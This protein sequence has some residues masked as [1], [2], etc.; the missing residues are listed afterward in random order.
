MKKYLLL[1]AILSGCYRN[2]N[3]EEVLAA[4]ENKEKSRLEK[5]EYDW[6]DQEVDG[7]KYRVF[8]KKYTT[9]QTGYCVFVV[10]LTKDKLEVKALESKLKIKED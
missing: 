2:D 3:R 10:N 9:T 4:S 1:I 7:M 5:S 8:F 6:E